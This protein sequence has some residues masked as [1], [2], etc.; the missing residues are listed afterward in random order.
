VGPTIKSFKLK[1]YRET[2]NPDS[3]YVELVTLEQGMGDYLTVQ[4]DDNTVGNVNNKAFSV[5]KD[6]LKLNQDSTDMASISP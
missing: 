5:D 4:F 3:P 1:K 2:T 6:Y